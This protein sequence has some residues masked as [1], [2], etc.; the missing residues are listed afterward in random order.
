[1]IVVEAGAQQ[2]FAEESIK[3]ERERKI[4]TENI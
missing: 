3:N 1:V 2:F 4:L